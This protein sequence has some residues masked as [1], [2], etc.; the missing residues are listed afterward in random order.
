MK[1]SA[2][3]ILY[4]RIAQPEYFLVHPGGPYWAGKDEW[5]IPKGEFT[6]EDPLTAALREFKE[7][8]G[9]TPEVKNMIALSPV[10]MK[11]SKIVYAWGIEG[12]TD[13]GNIRSNTF[14]IEWPPRSGKMQT[15]PEI[16]KAGWFTLNE[17]LKKIHSYQVALIDELAQRI[18]NG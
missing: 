14:E 4:R 2:G 18:V 8:T 15:F 12:N 1:K 9:F 13:A 16:D 17:A 10:K 6:D 5:S 7:E 3:I 11:S